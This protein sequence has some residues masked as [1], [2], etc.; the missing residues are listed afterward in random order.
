MR[1]CENAARFYMA[2]RHNPEQMLLDLA[3]TEGPRFVHLP[4]TPEFE[5]VCDE[6]IAAHRDSLPEIRFYLDET[7]NDGHTTY[8][9]IAGVC[10]IN[11]KQFEKHHAALAQ[12]RSEEGWPETIHFSDTSEH[13]VN[14]AVALLQ[15]LH[16][17]R[18]GILFLGYSLASR[19]RTHQD[20]FTLFIQLIMDS[21]RYLRD[22][23]CLGGHR[24]VR[25]IKEAE[26]GFDNIFLHKMTKQLGD[27]VA[28]EFPGELTVSPVEAVPKGRTVLLE[29]ADLVAGG[30]QRRALHKGRNPKDRL[31][32]AIMNVTGFEDHADLGTVFK[33]YP[34]G[35]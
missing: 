21:L 30:M 3:R 10:I 35:S 18:S 9:G 13:N 29:C 8:T 2:K 31:A 14:R 12:W 32:E 23:N 28:S 17:R 33:H 16:S 27:A 7:G 26:E 15:Q 24:S 11:W 19:G 34:T 4:Y 20:I 25:V 5:A 1:F 6:Y 22:Q